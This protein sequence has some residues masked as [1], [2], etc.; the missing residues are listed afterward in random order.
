MRKT[1]CANRGLNAK[2]P[3]LDDDVL[4]WIQGHRQNGKE[5]FF[6]SLALQSNNKNGKNIFFKKIA[7]KLRCVL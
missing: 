2:W 6:F 5:F 4:K 1:K 7:Q 3:K